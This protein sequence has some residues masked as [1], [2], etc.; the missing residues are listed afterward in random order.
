MM[1]DWNEFPLIYRYVWIMDSIG[2][3]F[4]GLYL[5]LSSY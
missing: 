4:V 1:I 3:E 2:T 5:V